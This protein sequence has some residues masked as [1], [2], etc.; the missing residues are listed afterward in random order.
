[1]RPIDY[2]ERLSF[3]RAGGSDAEKRAADSIFGWIAEMGVDVQQ[4]LFPVLTFSDMVGEMMPI[5]SNIKS[6][7]ISPVGLAA[8][9]ENLEGEVYLLT[10]AEAKLADVQELTG[11]IVFLA[12]YPRYSWIELCVRAGAKAMICVVDDTK[13]RAY[14]KLSQTAAREFGEKLPIAT[15]AY[16][17]AI[18]LVRSDVRRVSI[19]LSQKK[20]YGQSV[21][22]VAQIEGSTARQIIFTA[23][24][25]STPCSPGAQ[26]NAA[27]SAELLHLISLLRGKKFR[28]TLKF[29]FCGAEEMGLL[30]SKAFSS[31]HIAELDRTDLVINLDIGGDPFTNI[32]IKATGSPELAT[33]AR[34][35]CYA[36]GF[37]ASIKEDIYS[38][39]NMPFAKHGVPS[40][41]IARG[42]V[43]G[44]GHSPYDSAD[45]CADRALA[46]LVRCT[47]VITEFV[48]DSKI[49]PFPREISDLI[50]RK[51]ENY[52]DER[53]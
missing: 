34:S 37:G 44:R 19:S 2:L 24:L 13:E 11:K 18:N 40:L 23:H 27:G 35:M 25:D 33:F 15:I 7:H 39:D 38:S 43:D 3:V 30:G 12:Q 41:S 53:K 50:R 21:N 29:V 20:F 31:E 42:G 6:F 17:Y 10:A 16:H 8:N 14:A 36:H 45:R 48:A 22:V 47:Q 52:F 26:D 4:E 49:L 46:E 5:D 9:C 1:M 32:F 28:R 51:V